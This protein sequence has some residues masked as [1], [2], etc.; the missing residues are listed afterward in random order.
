MKIISQNEID[1]AALKYTRAYIDFDKE[2]SLS[3]EDLID[4]A[5]FDLKSVIDLAE[6]RLKI[7]ALKFLKYI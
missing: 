2:I 7:L 6:S 5:K 3:T 1:E 4:Y